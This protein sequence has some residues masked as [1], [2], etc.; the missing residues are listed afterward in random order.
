MVVILEMDGSQ[1]SDPAEHVLPLVL[2]PLHVENL[3]PQALPGSNNSESCIQGP[4][5][6][7]HSLPQLDMP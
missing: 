5:Q 7:S 6:Y 4:P 2:V 1:L 3:L